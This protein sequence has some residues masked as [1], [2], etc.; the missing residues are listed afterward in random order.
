MNRTDVR[1]RLSMMARIMRPVA[2]RAGR[3]V[4]L[5]VLLRGGGYARDL[6][7]RRNRHR[8]VT[9]RKNG[10]Y[11]T[12][13]PRGRPLGGIRHPA[14]GRHAAVALVRL[15]V[16][17]A[18]GER[19]TGDLELRYPMIL[20]RGDRGEPGLREG[21][22]LEVLRAGIRR[23][24]RRRGSDHHV[25]ARL[26]TVHR[27]QDNLQRERIRS[28]DLGYLQTKRGPRDKCLHS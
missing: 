9:G 20:V 11:G 14:D 28:L 3:A 6:H 7:R 16:P 17:E 23:R 18:L 21:E 5:M 12:R 4:K 13:G 8:V 10:A 24:A 2:T 15:A 25:A 26:I 19:V 22:R 27:V 1:R